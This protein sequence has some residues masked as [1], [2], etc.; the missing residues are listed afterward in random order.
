M[1]NLDT[2]VEDGLQEVADELVSKRLGLSATVASQIDRYRRSA[3]RDSAVSWGEAVSV[4][5]LVGRRSDASLVYAD[6]GR[7][8]ARHGVKRLPGITRLLLRM[9]PRRLRRVVGRRVS[10]RVAADVVG[11]RLRTERSGSRVEL[12]RS[13]ATEAMVEGVGCIFYASAIAELLRLLSGFE[14]AVAHDSCRSKG[15]DQ[16]RWRTATTEGY[17]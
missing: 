17:E 14:G 2:P 16:C 11:A 8:A 9:A 12:T 6:A 5:R 7:R 4:F 10:A 3:D 13:L 15:E 1:K